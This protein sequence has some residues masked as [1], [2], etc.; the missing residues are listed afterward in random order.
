MGSKKAFKG[1]TGQRDHRVKTQ[2]RQWHRETETLCA[3]NKA[4]GGWLLHHRSGAGGEGQGSWITG[5][6]HPQISF[7]TVTIL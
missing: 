2:L 7:F 6:W 3:E 1:D 4:G 5:A